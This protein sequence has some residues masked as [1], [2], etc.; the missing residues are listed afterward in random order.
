ML[1][2]KK[3]ECGTGVKIKGNGSR[4][5]KFK[6]LANKTEATFLL[7]SANDLYQFHCSKHRKAYK[8]SP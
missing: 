5:D 1:K 6:L 3:Q 2:Q 4:N 7:D 8:H